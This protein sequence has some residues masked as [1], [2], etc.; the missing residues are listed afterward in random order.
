MAYHDLHL[1]HCMKGFDI[2]IFLLPSH[3][4]KIVDETEILLL[5]HSP[6]YPPHDHP[7]CEN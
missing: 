3:F 1:I 6:Q 7:L 2:I 5:Q 4:T